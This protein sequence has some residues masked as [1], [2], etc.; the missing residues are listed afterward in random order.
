MFREV[1]ND[2]SQKNVAPQPWVIVAVLLWAVVHDRPHSWACRWHQ[3]FTWVA[4]KLLINGVRIPTNQGRMTEMEKVLKRWAN[5]K[6]KCRNRRLP[7]PT[8]IDIFLTLA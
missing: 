7:P 4:A 6:P 3:V 1:G 8:G 5:E 2:F